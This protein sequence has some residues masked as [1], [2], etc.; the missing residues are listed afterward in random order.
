MKHRAPGFKLLLFLLTG[1]I[2][3]VAVAWGC[4][5]AWDRVAWE[6]DE[7]I[8]ISVFRVVGDGAGWFEMKAGVPLRCLRGI[9]SSH[10]EWD[11]VTRS[12]SVNTTTTGFLEIARLSGGGNVVVPVSPL[13]RLRDQHDVLRIH[14]LDAVCVSVRGA[15]KTS[16]EARPVCIMRVFAA[17]ICE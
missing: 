15:A 2:V 11:P 9:Q 8:G 14:P 17:P 13:A 3:N 12:G 10:R 4:A 5:L 1:A 6:R 7:T 16:K